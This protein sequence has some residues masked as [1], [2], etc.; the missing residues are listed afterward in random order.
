ML[1]KLAG[2]RGRPSLAN[3]VSISNAAGRMPW[4]CIEAIAAAILAAYCSASCASVVPAGAWYRH[5]IGTARAWAAKGSG[6]G[7]AVVT[8]ASDA[9][10]P[11]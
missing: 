6:E 2:T 7:R 9:E 8:S 1:T 3:R 10:L 4:A 5:G 11:W